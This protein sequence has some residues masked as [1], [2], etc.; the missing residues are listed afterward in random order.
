MTELERSE[1]AKILM[2]L[3]AG[4]GFGEQ[5]AA[6]DQAKGEWAEVNAR[7][8]RGMIR[9]GDRRSGRPRR[10]PR[11]RREMEI[12]ERAADRSREETREWADVRPPAIW[13]GATPGANWGLREGVR[14]PLAGG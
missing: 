3:S 14:G 10:R 7:L 13:R 9:A 1:V 4:I 2:L 8:L 12:R 6:L 5:L 11:K